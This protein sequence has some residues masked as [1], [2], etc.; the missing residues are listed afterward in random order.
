MLEAK[1]DAASQLKKIVE[2][3]RDMLGECNIECNETGLALQSLDKSHIVL[4]SLLLGSDGFS[5]Y[6]CDRGVTLGLNINSLATVLRCANNDD[7]LTLRSEDRANELIL[8][9]E[10]S[11]ADRISEFNLRLMD[12][13][14]EYLAIPET[15]YAATVVMSAAVLQRTLRDLSALSEAVTI[16]IDKEGIRF[17]A[18]GDLGKGSTHFK[19][20]VDMENAENSINIT[21]SEPVSLSFNLQYFSNITKASSLSSTVTLQMTAGMPA[22]IEYKLPSGH[23]R[24]YFAPKIEDDPYA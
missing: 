11:K 10:D 17:S 5:E 1:L 14:Q 6:R 19:P 9:F 23:V 4:V 20:C 16:E 18:E 15:E 13:D 8:T 21:L 7:I 22:Q 3:I 24:Y 2:A 12:I